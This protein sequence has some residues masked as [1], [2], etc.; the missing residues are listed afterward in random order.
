[1]AMVKNIPEGR[2]ISAHY[3][4]DGKTYGKAV[5]KSRARH[6]RGIRTCSVCKHEQK[7][8]IVKPY[9]QCSECRL[10]N[11]GAGQ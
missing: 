4:K 2:I 7:V 5:K 11:I 9:W 6:E 3:H 1:M 10:I 8:K